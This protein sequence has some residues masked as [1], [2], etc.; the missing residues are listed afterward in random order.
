MLYVAYFGVVITHCYYDW[1]GSNSLVKTSVKIITILWVSTAAKRQVD[2]I[3]VHYY[4]ETDRNYMFEQTI[5]Q[6]CNRISLAVERRV[7]RTVGCAF[8]SW[9]M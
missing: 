3:L 4:D 8:F 7:N 6:M 1:Q 9:L 5:P 2:L